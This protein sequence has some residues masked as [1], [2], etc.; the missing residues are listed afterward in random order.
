MNNNT[1]NDKSVVKTAENTDIAPTASPNHQSAKRMRHIARRP[2]QTSPAHVPT[3]P[4]IYA[5]PDSIGPSQ[6]MR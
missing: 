2:G 5:H 3:S 6:H 4:S 1:N